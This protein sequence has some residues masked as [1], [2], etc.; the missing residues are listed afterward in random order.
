NHAL[1]LKT[2]EMRPGA[3]KPGL[4]L[5]GN[6]DAA[7]GPHMLINVLEISVGKNHHPA[8]ALNGFG[9]EAG[10][11]ARCG[12]VDQLLYVGGVFFAGIRIIAAVRSTIQIREGGVMDAKAVRH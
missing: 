3:A 1:R 7:S 12:K 8:D 4:D 9:D 11:L 6:A 5:V 2:P 10:N